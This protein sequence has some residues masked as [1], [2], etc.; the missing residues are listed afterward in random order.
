MSTCKR[1]ATGALLALALA[2]AAHAGD[3]LYLRWDNCFGD[4]GVY[5]K[6]F[7]C[8]TNTGSETLVGSFRMAAT[9][10]QVTAVEIIVDLA[11]L[12]STMPAWWSM[13]S[14]SPVGCRP[15]SLTASFAPPATSTTCLD[16]WTFSGGAGGFSQ[17]APAPQPWPYWRIKGIF[18][19]PSS[20]TVTA[21]AGQE[22]FAFLLRIKHAQTVG[23]GSCD[24]CLTP[25]CIAWDYARVDRATPLPW[26]DVL[27]A[28]TAANGSNVTWQPGAVAA[29]RGS[30]SPNRPCNVYVECQSVTPA[31]TSTWG[32]I[33]S[34]YR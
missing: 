17:D 23:P 1:L 22:I 11:A 21:E 14:G 31:R 28:N 18:G 34:L 15:T 29:T 12:G 26:I 16:L 24:G 8:D 30:C 9:T 20:S 33:K 27:G 7:A 4:G 6:T 10:D 19:V 25:V 5:N 3:E 13:R 2:P 32:S